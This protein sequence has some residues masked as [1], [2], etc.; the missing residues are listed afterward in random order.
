MIRAFCI[1]II[2]LFFINF[3][4][5]FIQIKCFSF[6]ELSYVNMINCLHEEKIVNYWIM[7]TN[8]SI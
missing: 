8:V 1:K 2:F 7:E 4:L 6:Q 5:H 3:S